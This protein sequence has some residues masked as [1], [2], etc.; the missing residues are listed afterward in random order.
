M[1]ES[2]IEPQC[3]NTMNQKGPGQQKEESGAGAALPDRG[4]DFESLKEKD[5]VRTR[6]TELLKRD[7][8]LDI[9]VVGSCGIFYCEGG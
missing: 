9:K 2:K 1:I 8:G 5:Q 4:R 7:C 3:I 6:T